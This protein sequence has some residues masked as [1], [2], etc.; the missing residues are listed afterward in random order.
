MSTNALLMFKQQ[1]PSVFSAALPVTFA[2]IP[3]DDLFKSLVEHEEL[4]LFC[5]VSVSDGVVQWY[6]D[7]TEIQ[8]SEH[9]TI[10]AEGTRRGVAIGSVT[11]SDAGVYTCR[12]GDS[13]LMFKV[14]VRGKW[15]FREGFK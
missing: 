12:T 3:E 1:R 15:P 2:E 11:L 4:I 7:G 8:P 6:K 5:E 9:V 13:V 14:N 10:R